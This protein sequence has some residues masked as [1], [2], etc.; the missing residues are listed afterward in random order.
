MN[1]R[2]GTISGLKL[3]KKETKAMWLGSMKNSKSK[4][5]KFKSTRDPVK[6]LET[7]ISYNHVKNGKE[8]FFLPKLEK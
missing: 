5:L 2:F 1:E 6:V 3:N 7:S 8:N 4:I